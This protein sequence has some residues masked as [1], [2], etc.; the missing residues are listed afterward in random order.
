MH[1]GN[2]TSLTGTGIALGG[3][4]AGTIGAITIG[5]DI[6]KTIVQNEN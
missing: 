3:L 1:H 5:E 4:A 6:I 2:S